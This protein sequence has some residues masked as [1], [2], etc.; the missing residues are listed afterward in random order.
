MGTYYK[1]RG[2]AAWLSLSLLFSSSVEAFDLG[3]AAKAGMEE[4]ERK[5]V[6]VLRRACDNRVGLCISAPE[7]LHDH[8]AKAINEQTEALEIPWPAYYLTASDD[9]NIHVIS[10]N[11]DYQ[12]EDLDPRANGAIDFLVH[13][14]IAA[15]QLEQWA[16]SI[17]YSE[18]QIKKLE[19]EM[20]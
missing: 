5:K 8:I 16:R 18:E 1:G 3:A 12:V 10:K 20:Q 17:K 2:A 6:E 15:L 19:A 14:V 11:E 9:G 13:R 7:E 4:R